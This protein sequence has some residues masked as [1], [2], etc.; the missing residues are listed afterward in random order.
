MRDPAR[1]PVEHIRRFSGFQTLPVGPHFQSHFP[2]SLSCCRVLMRP[3]LASSSRLLE[4]VRGLAR[5]R[6]SCWWSVVLTGLSGSRQVKGHRFILRSGNYQ[7]QTVQ[8]R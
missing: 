1:R 5:L 3:G 4:N 8:K 2:C 7:G 6:F